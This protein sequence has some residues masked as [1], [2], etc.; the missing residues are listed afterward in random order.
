MDRGGVTGRRLRSRAADAVCQR[1]AVT[2]AGPRRPPFLRASRH[3]AL[4]A[5]VHIVEEVEAHAPEGPAAGGGRSSPS[6]PGRRHFRQQGLP[7]RRFLGGHGYAYDKKKVSGLQLLFFLWM[8]QVV[9]LQCTFREM[10][11]KYLK[12]F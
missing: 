7:A 12:T 2:A 11:L 6:L 3:Q 8:Y 10:K 4:Q 1:A 5:V 9:E